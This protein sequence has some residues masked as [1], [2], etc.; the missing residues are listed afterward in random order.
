MGNKIIIYRLLHLNCLTNFQLLY[1]FL[2]LQQLQSIFSIF[3]IKLQLFIYLI[4]PSVYVHFGYNVAF[5]IKSS[6]PYTSQQGAY[7]FT[8][9]SI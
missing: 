4:C 7:C 5:E 3:K 8:F 2:F 1:T 9:G 6:F